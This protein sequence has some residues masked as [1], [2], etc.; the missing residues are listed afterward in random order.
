MF[1]IRAADAPEHLYATAATLA[2]AERVVEQLVEDTRAQVVTNGEG[3]TQLWV[4]TAIYRM[5]AR[6]LNRGGGGLCVP[7]R[8][9]G[10][11]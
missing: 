2:D 1:E 7:P 4:Q 6:S 8:Q 10:A 9:R 11:D 3:A 5:T